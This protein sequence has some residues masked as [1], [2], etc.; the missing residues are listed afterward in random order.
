M[1]DFD[2]EEGTPDKP[3]LNPDDAFALMC[4]AAHRIGTLIDQAWSFQKEVIPERLPAL[5]AEFE[6]KAAVVRAALE[7]WGYLK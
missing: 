6:E 7:Q 3:A 5:L 4:M 2:G 1:I